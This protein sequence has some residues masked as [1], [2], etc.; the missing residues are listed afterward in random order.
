MSESN[1]ATL[2]YIEEST[3]GTTPA[4]PVNYVRMTSESIG[5]EMTTA[6][7]NEIRSDRLVADIIR[8]GISVGGDIGIELSY[9]A[10]DALIAGVMQSAWSSAVAVAASTTIGFT[11]VGNH[12]TDSA[13][14]FTNVVVGQFIKVS[15]AVNAGNNGYHLVT[16]KTSANDITVST[17]LTTEAA[18]GSIN[19]KSAYIRN[20]TTKKSFTFEKFFGGL[21]ADEYVSFTG[22]VMDSM[23]LTIKPGSIIEG[24]FALQGQDAAA[25]NTSVGTGPAVAAPTA[26]VLN[27]IDNVSNVMEA[28][29]AAPYD[30]VEISFTVSNSLRTRQKVASLP[31]AGVMLGTIQI[32]GNFRAY[33]ASKALYEKYLNFTATD[34][35]FVVSDVAGNSYLFYFPQVKFTSGNPA[36][37][38]LD[39]DVMLEMGFTAYRDPSLLFA[40]QICRFPA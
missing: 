22:C 15:G 13:S 24:S 32:T 7:S 27:A 30:I 4:N 33:F 19:V 25:S 14:A 29:V 8:T 31:M 26:D 21:V 6:T 16:V 20:G 1:R 11:S 28:G 3:W 5:M 39:Q 10:H 38:G 18:G 17:T 37:S 40:M 34:L 23:Q 2:G 35:S 9:G 36:A 12:I